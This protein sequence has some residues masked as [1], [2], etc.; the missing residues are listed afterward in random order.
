MAQIRIKFSGRVLPD[1]NPDY[2]LA[3]FPDG[4]PVIDG[5]A[6]YFDPDFGDYDWLVVYEDLMYPTSR[7]ISSRI[8]PLACH[9]ENTLI[10]LQE[11]ASIKIYGAQFLSQYGHV[12]SFQTPDTINHP[13][14]IWQVT[15]VRWFYGRP[16]G[17]NDHDYVSVDALRSRKY[18]DKNRSISTVCSN[19]LVWARH[20]PRKRKVS[21]DGSLQISRRYRERNRAPLLD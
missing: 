12:L 16:L 4:K 18:V 13:N 21:G 11:P 3:L 2:W 17:E 5:C 9:R 8:E 6:F 14:H 19:K 1:Q 10:M 20:S 7:L 15:P